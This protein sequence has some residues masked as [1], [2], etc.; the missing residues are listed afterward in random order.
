MSHRG[1]RSIPASQFFAGFFTTVLAEDEVLTKSA[2]LFLRPALAGGS[3]SSP[4][5]VAISRWRG[6]PPLSMELSEARAPPASSSLERPI[7]PCG[8]LVR[9]RSS[10]PG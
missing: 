4:S 1:E 5:A 3:E 2:S 8:P 7:A 10:T 6:L 9:K